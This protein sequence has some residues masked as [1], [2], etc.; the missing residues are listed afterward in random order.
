MSIATIGS[1]IES[2]SPV[3]SFWGRHKVESE[4]CGVFMVEERRQP[5]SIKIR[6][7]IIRKAHHRAIESQRT[8]GEWIEG[9]IEEKASRE[10]WEQQEESNLMVP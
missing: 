7:S 10:E 8:L 6:P 5:R 3:F 4:L 1:S 9:A 2:K